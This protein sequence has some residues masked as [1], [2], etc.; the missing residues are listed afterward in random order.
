MDVNYQI[1]VL[2]ERAVAIAVEE[3]ERLARKALREHPDVK[4]FVMGMGRALFVV[5]EDE[6]HE[7][8]VGVDEDDRFKELSEFLGR[9]DNDLRV[10]GI[11]MRF[12]AD[13]PKVTEW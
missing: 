12:T 9:W 7:D 8:I 5:H 4:E 11:A 13:G 2:L 10:T 1:D 3:T 6:E